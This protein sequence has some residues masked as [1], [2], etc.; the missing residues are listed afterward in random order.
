MENAETERLASRRVYDLMINT[1]EPC[2]RCGSY[3][4][5]FEKD[6][7]ILSKEILRGGV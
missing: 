6:E 7:K 4:K 2:R 3:F 5:P 1:R